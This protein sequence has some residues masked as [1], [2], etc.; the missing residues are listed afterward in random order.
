MYFQ[1]EGLKI[2]SQKKK[3]YFTT[4]CIERV[5]QI[6][7]FNYDNT[8]LEPRNIVEDIITDLISDNLDSLK[9]EKQKEILSDLIPN[10][11]EMGSEFTPS[12]LAGV[13]ILHLLNCI[14]SYNDE[15]IIHALE[16]SLQAVDSFSEYNE[17]GLEEEK[18]WHKKSLD[19][20]NNNETYPTDEIKAINKEYPKWSEMWRD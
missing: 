14:I 1:I 17:S 6:F 13:A 4:C 12:M 10:I 9:A 20:I 3:I 11:D 18:I 8:V 7:E 5:V 2:L 15:D 16:Y 19:I